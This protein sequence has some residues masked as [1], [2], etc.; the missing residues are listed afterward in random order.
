MDIPTDIIKYILEYSG[1][2]NTAIYLN[3]DTKNIYNPNIHTYAWACENSQLEIV[4]WLHKNNIK[5]NVNLTDIASMYG[6]MEILV[7]IHT[8]TEEVGTTD[9]IDYASVNGHL[10]IV[11]WLLKKNYKFTDNAIMWSVAR[12]HYDIYNIL[13]NTRS[14]CYFSKLIHKFI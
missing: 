5:I 10:H 11:E 14:R 13:T 9:S 2:L 7:W 12:K 8:H 6:Q 1:D 3:L 4:K